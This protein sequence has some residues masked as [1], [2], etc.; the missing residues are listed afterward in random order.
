MVTNIIESLE[1]EFGKMTVTRGRN[2]NSVGME[3][4]FRSDG[5][6]NLRMQGYLEEFMQTFGEVIKNG[7]RTP[8]KRNLF[9]KRERIDI[10]LA[11]AFLC[12]RVAH[13]TV[14]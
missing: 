14:F 4:K 7:G 1:S 2:D 11:I 13:P 8:A 6:F 5:S 3:D 12:T 10:D 9:D